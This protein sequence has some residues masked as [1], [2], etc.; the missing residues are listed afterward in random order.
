MLCDDKVAH[1]VFQVPEE[2]AQEVEGASEQ[3]GAGRRWTKCIS[4]V[5]G[6][7]CINLG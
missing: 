3:Y 2:R 1:K 5:F 6:G 7:G 4:T